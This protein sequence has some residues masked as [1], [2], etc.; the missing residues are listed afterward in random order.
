MKDPIIEKIALHRENG[1]ETEADCVYLPSQIR[2][3]MKQ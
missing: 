3:F 2:K 1:F